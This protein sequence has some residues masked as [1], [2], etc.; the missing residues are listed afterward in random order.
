MF[1]ITDQINMQFVLSEPI[2]TKSGDLIGVLELGR[3]ASNLRFS[4]E[5]EEIV[6]SYL[7]WATVVLDCTNIHYENTQSELMF[8]SFDKITRYLHYYYT[9]LLMSVYSGWS[10]E[11]SGDFS[12]FLIVFG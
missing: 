10:L 6:K 5:D 2:L 8:N 9:T 7:S 3:K 11:T 1:P 12:L 4:E